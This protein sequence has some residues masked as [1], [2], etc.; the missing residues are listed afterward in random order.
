MA[1]L[2]DRDVVET[3]FRNLDHRE[4][5]GYER[6]AVRLTFRDGVVVDAIVYIA[7]VGNHAWLGPA[8]D[9][10]MVSQI[11]RAAG[12]SGANIDYLNDL[13]A[14]LRD[15]G[16]KDPHVFRLE[17]MARAYMARQE[18]SDGHTIRQASSKL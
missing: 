9:E 13:A 6:H 18:G 14:A 3:V 8:G 4:K 1:Y 2:V 12:P 10:E 5:N 7:A 11:C 15:L 17:S 16:V